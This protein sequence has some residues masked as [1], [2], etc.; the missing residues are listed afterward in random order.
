MPHTQQLLVHMMVTF[1]DYGTTMKHIY[2]KMDSNT[3]GNNYYSRRNNN[4][5]LHR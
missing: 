2:M 3:A 1:A 4:D 5:H